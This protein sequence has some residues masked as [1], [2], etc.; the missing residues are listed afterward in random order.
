MAAAKWEVAVTEK[1]EAAY[2]KRIENQIIEDT[3]LAKVNNTLTRRMRL[4]E[5][6]KRDEE[7]YESELN[8]SGLSFRREHI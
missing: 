4:I 8:L 1:D 5:L 6:Y 7:R 3:K 2:R